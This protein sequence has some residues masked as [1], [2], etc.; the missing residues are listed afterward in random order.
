MLYKK[1]HWQVYLSSIYTKKV[2]FTLKTDATH[3]PWVS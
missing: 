3:A 2:V 1:R